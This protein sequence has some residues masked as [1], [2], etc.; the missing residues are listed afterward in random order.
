ML[1][2]KLK[3]FKEEMAG[4]NAPNPIYELDKSDLDCNCYIVNRQSLLKVAKIMSTLTMLG[5]QLFLFKLIVVYQ[6]QMFLRY[7]K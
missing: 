4:L 7:F 3:K 2:L 6:L 1:N 5:K